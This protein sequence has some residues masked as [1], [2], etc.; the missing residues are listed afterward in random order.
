MLAV[1]RSIGDDQIEGVFPRPKVTYF[2]VKKEIKLIIG[3]DGLFETLTYQEVGKFVQQNK[4]WS[5]K[6]LSCEF[7]KKAN[8]TGI[9]DNITAMVA[10]LLLDAD[11]FHAKENYRRK[12]V[13]EWR[14]IR[15][16]MSIAINGFGR[17]G[18]FVLRA[19]LKRDNIQVV[20]V[21]D[22]VSPENLA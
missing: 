13:D 2:P 14:V 9:S 3:S 1:A 11:L 6:N 18:R 20:A 5:N 12:K 17:I 8:A 10:S 21:N 16:V 15:M 4:I 19:A 7:L 22:L